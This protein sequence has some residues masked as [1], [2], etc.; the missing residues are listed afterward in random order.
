M[1]RRAPDPIRSTGTDDPTLAARL[2]RLGR[3]LDALTPATP[4]VSEKNPGPKGDAVGLAKG[5]RMSSEL[6]AG[7]IVGGVIGWGLDWLTGYRPWGIMIF[8]LLGFVGGTLNVLRSA[9]LV[10]Q[11][12]IPDEK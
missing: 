5:L 3:E 11:P 12:K 8:M 4:Q 6:V 1:A 7:V 10:A 9:G 2:D